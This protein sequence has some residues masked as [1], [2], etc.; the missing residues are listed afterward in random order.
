MLVSLD[1][2]DVCPETCPQGSA[3]YNNLRELNR[4]GYRPT[5]FV[6][7]N[8]M[9]RNDLRDNFEWV[10]DIENFCTIEAHGYFHTGSYYYD[11]EF[12]SL[13]YKDLIARLTAMM[14]TYCVVRLNPK[15]LRPPGWLY[16]S[17]FT[18]V[19]K[20]FIPYLS[21]R[22]DKN[23]QLNHVHKLEEPKKECVILHAHVNKEYGENNI[24]DPTIFK[25]VVKWLEEHQFE[26]VTVREMYDQLY[27]KSAKSVSD[28]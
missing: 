3:P 24:D 13:S 6:P 20:S 16:S 10:R 7:A 8:M 15:V 22:V 23:I 5:V 28:E 27:N 21:Q 9:G 25:N 11:C 19:Y 4:M 17:E 1:C 12:L 14:N 2:D 26:Y 18:E